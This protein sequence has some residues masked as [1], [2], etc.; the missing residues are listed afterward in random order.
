MGAGFSAAGLGLR[1]LLATLNVDASVLDLL[2]LIPNLPGRIAAPG[3]SE[4]I[5][6]PIPIGCARQQR[7]VV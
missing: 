4:A 7:G 5:S 2:A 3:A 1:G 6:P